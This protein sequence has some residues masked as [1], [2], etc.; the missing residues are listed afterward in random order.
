[1]NQLLKK[2]R[3]RT[4]NTE[5][6]TKLIHAA[7]VLSQ[8]YMIVQQVSAGYSDNCYMK[9]RTHHKIGTKSHRHFLQVNS[10]T[11]SDHCEQMQLLDVNRAYENC[12]LSFFMKLVIFIAKDLIKSLAASLRHKIDNSITWYTRS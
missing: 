11:F 7:A 6:W 9:V 1:M 4:L 3:D 5:E 2:F 8:R 12:T 10:I